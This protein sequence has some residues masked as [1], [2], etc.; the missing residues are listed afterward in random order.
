MNARDLPVYRE[1][2][3]IL[4]QLQNNRVIVVE[5]PT[6]SGKTTQLPIILHEAGYTEK[7]MVGITQPRRIATLS[8][9]DY[10]AK[11]LES[12]VGDFVGYK[13]RFDDKTNAKTRLKILTDGTLLQEIKAD[14]SLSAYSVIMVDEAHE[15][16]LNID[17]ILGLLKEISS[18]RP[19]FRIIIS[20]ATINSEVFSAYFNGA[21]IVRIDTPTYPVDIFWR[22]GPDGQPLPE[23]LMRDQI[24][25]LVSE[26]VGEREGD[27]LVFLPGE[28]LIK[29]TASALAFSTVKQ[30]LH[31][32]PLYGRLS[33]EDQHRVFDDPPPGMTKVI[34][35]TNIA[36]TS[37]TI[38]GVTTVIDSGLAKINYYNP[39]TF[40]SSLQEDKVSRSSALQRTGRA[41]RTQPGVCYRLYGEKDFNE[42]SLFTREEIYRTDLSEVVLR[43]AEI[44]IRDFESFDFLSPPGKPGIQGA[45]EVL[46]LLDALKG[47][48]SLSETGRMMAQFPLLPRHARMI[49][50][51]ILRYPE[52]IEEITIA[53]SFLSTDSPFL[54]PQGEEMEAR[55]AHHF[56]RDDNGDFVSYLRIFKAY[57]QAPQKETFCKHYYLEPRTMAELVNIQGQLEEIVSRLGV[58]I[59]KGGAVSDYLCAAAKG[60]IQFV[61]TATGRGIYRSLTAE[62]IMIHPGSVLFRESPPYIVA[63][64]IVRTSRIYARSVSPIRKEWLERI[65]PKLAKA[66]TEA[67][68]QT[69][70]GD[71]PKADDNPWQVRIGPEVFTLKT[72][73]GKDKILLMPW[74]KIQRVL[75]NVPPTAIP[76]LKNMKG[77]VESRDRLIMEGVRVNR[78][79][80]LSRMIDFSDI[81]EEWPQGQSYTGTKRLEKLAV[82]LENLIHPCPPRTKSRELGFFALQSDGR[83]QYWFKVQKTFQTALT[84]SLSALEQ[85]ADDKEA[86]EL[87]PQSW[88]FINGAYRRLNTLIG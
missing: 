48:H 60:L 64:E 24:V 18:R 80:E 74:E 29:E 12:P 34:L 11:Q 88:K 68:R 39:R 86:G 65:D 42:R 73:G 66:L 21:P 22:P 9:C 3:R 78:I 30:S 83:G 27:I 55:R 72:L 4:A 58:P 32:L 82:H 20:S 77:R 14:Q 63:G 52:V 40:T 45:V 10:I 25:K 69:P 84:E 53:A 44:G 51:A 36:E 87:T 49:V 59:G 61:C 35:S 76:D 1:K 37:V 5:S 71:E 31:I 2:E 81:L 67:T 50:E 19:E 8:V 70:H 15:R 7:G 56:F 46:F 54:L 6:G 23:E 38:D 75:A 62:K 33:K 16:S 41:G 43:M 57:L 26:V 47:D 85:L 17:F 13:M 79:L 28:K